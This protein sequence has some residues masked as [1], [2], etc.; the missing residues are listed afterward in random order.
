MTVYFSI[1]TLN[2]YKHVEI[3]PTDPSQTSLT[4]DGQFTK[5]DA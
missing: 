5:S 2:I 3:S 4:N 1:R